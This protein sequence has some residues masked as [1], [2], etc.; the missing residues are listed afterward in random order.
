MNIHMETTKLSVYTD[1]GARGNPGPAG[2]GVIIFDSNDNLVDVANFYLGTATNNQAEYTALLKAVTIVKKYAPTEVTFYLDSELV[3]KQLNKEY[4]IKDA[5]LRGL[6][7]KIEA[8]LSESGIN[9]FTFKHIPREQNK[10]AD[11]LVN[12]AMDIALAK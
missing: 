1:G 4:K 7:E 11:K 5:N 3:V 12:L 2:C 10:F 6:A 8:M 9:K